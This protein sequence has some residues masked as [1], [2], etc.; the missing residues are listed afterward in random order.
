MLMFACA[1]PLDK[2]VDR[3]VDVKARAFSFFFKPQKT[4]HLPDVD[5]KTADSFRATLKVSAAR[6]F[7]PSTIAALDVT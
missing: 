3:A 4:W 7:G 2:V 5:D 6:Y 1:G